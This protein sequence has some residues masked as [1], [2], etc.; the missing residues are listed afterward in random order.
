MG[1]EGSILGAPK[2]EGL[3]PDFKVK[4]QQVI[5]KMKAKGWNLRV[6]WAKRT[7]EENDDLVKKGFASKNSKHLDGKA[8]D[9]IDRKV[10][11]SADRNHEYYKHLEEVTKEVGVKWGGSFRERWDPCHIEAK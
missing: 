5:K 10:G 1:K 6:V 9:L 2:L 7:K 8:L 11:Y 4:A 3:D